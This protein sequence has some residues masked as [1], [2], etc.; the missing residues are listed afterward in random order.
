MLQAQVHFWSLLSDASFVR[1]AGLVF[2]LI[3]NTRLKEIMCKES[4]DG[5]GDGG[6]SKVKN[7]P[8]QF[9]IQNVI[10]LIKWILVFLAGQSKHGMWDV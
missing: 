9:W 10:S 5:G 3:F 7:I 4:H 2:C 8:F 6:I 1:F